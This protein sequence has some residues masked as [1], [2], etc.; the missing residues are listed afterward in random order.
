MIVE[1]VWSD[2]MPINLAFQTRMFRPLDCTPA[3]P[4]DPL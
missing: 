4:Q 2:G 1:V 3:E